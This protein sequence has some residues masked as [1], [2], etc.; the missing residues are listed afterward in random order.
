MQTLTSLAIPLGGADF[1][2]VDDGEMHSQ[3][4]VVGEVEHHL[5]PRRELLGRTAGRFAGDAVQPPG[6][7]IGLLPQHR[8]EQFVLRREVPVERP[9]RQPGALEDRGHRDRP[10]VRLVQAAVRSVDDAL[11]VID[12]R[13]IGLHDRRL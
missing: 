7:R 9:R 12:V 2:G 11:T 3:L 4:W 10:T 8:E 5:D 6:Q 1:V 13:R